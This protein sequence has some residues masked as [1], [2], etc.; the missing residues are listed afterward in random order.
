MKHNFI[1]QKF[2]Y[3]W[4]LKKYSRICFQLFY[5]ALLINFIYHTWIKKQI[6]IFFH[7][8][9]IRFVTLSSVYFPMLLPGW[10]SSNSNEGRHDLLQQFCFLNNDLVIWLFVK[11]YHFSI[12]D[13]YNLAWN[14]EIKKKNPFSVQKNFWPK[15][16]CSHFNLRV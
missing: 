11:K 12:N 2:M 9:L 5:S 7:S 1:F 13:L 14:Y 10:N 16:V 4:L 6:V 8:R 15:N 3:E